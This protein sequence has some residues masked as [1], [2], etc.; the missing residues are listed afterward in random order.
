MNLNRKPTKNK[1]YKK[2]AIQLSNEDALRLL[3]SEFP[4]INADLIAD[5]YQNLNGNYTLARDNLSVFQKNSEFQEIIDDALGQEPINDK[6]D[7]DV[8]IAKFDIHLQDFLT[9]RFKPDLNSNKEILIK[10]QLS[11]IV[12]NQ[13]K[14]EKSIEKNPKDSNLSL[15]EK[16][17]EKGFSDERNLLPCDVK[18]TKAKNK[19]QKF[20]RKIP[21]VIEQPRRNGWKRSGISTLEPE[22]SHFAEELAFE[23]DMKLVRAQVLEMIKNEVKEHKPIGNQGLIDELLSAQIEND[24]VLVQSFILSKLQKGKTQYSQI[25][26]P[27][28]ID[29]DFPSLSHCSETEEIKNKNLNFQSNKKKACKGKRNMLEEFDEAYVKQRKKDLN[30][31]FIAYLSNPNAEPLYNYEMTWH[32][33]PFNSQEISRVKSLG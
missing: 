27:N 20:S 31:P 24:I 10:K 15:K 11:D 21:E 4:N 8:L 29:Q 28:E 7:E 6:L 16:V 5:V 3:V 30:K 2:A 22:I 19:K 26:D 14:I 12:S 1:T 33:L 9:D 25:C 32:N 17:E 18:V 13:E 23:E